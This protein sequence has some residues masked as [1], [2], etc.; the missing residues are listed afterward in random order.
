VYFCVFFS[1]RGLGTITMQL[2]GGPLR[3]QSSRRDREKGVEPP[4]LDQLNAV[5]KG[6]LKDQN[7]LA[8][9]DQ[10][11][12]DG[13]KVG[14][15][16][17]Q[18]PAFHSPSWADYIAAIPLLE[19]RP[20]RSYFYRRA[21]LRKHL[22]LVRALRNFARQFDDPF[23]EGSLI[24]TRD[25]TIPSHEDLP[26]LADRAASFIEKFVS[27]DW[28]IRERNPRNALIAILRGT[29]RARTGKPHDRELSTVIDA[30]F[31]AAGRTELY[32]DNTTLDRIEKREKENRVKSFQTFEV[33]RRVEP[34][35]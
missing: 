8:A 15:L 34:N 33:L 23:C 16:S 9:L 11:E 17:P 6:V 4:T 32:L 30:A 1:F 19:N 26:D 24:S 31:R 12:R 20:S 25:T 3:K 7:A 14:H 22:P 2:H 5:W 28:Y 21:S 29:I 18:D 10:L 13:F 27:W 35:T